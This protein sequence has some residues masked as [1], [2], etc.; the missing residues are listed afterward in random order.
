MFR[1]QRMKMNDIPRNT[2]RWAFL[3]AVLALLSL[4]FAAPSQETHPTTPGLTSAEAS[5]DLSLEDT[6]KRASDALKAA[7][8]ILHK[9]LP[10]TIGASN[11]WVFALLN[12]ERSGAKTRVIA[13]V[14]SN[15]TK[16]GESYRMCMFLIE[17]MKSGR[18]PANS[19][20]TGSVIGVWEW[21]WVN[22]IGRGKSQVTLAPDGKVTCPDPGW[23]PGDWWIEDGKVLVYWPSPFPKTNLHYVMQFTL[24]PD[25]RTMSTTAGNYYYSSVSAAR[26][27]DVPGAVSPPS[28]GGNPPGAPLSRAE[29]EW[30]WKWQAFA[31]N[32]T[33]K[34]TLHRGGR[35]T[36][37]AKQEGSW[38]AQGDK[39]F[40]YWNGA[41]PKTDPAAVIEFLMAPDGK[42]MT[43]TIGNYYT[44]SV[45]ATR[46]GEVPRTDASGVPPP[47][48]GSGTG[49]VPPGVKPEDVWFQLGAP[50][51]PP[52]PLPLP[53]VGARNRKS[54]SLD[55]LGGLVLR[56]EPTAS[57]GE[58]QGG[59]LACELV[60]VTAEHVPDKNGPDLYDGQVQVNVK[61]TDEGR[62]YVADIYVGGHLDYPKDPSGGG[63][64]NE[65]VGGISYDGWVPAYD[66][67]RLGWD[68]DLYS[69]QKGKLRRYVFRMPRVLPA[70]IRVE[71][72]E[73]LPSGGTRFVGKMETQFDMPFQDYRI[74]G[75]GVLGK[76]ENSIQTF[77]ALLE[78][79]TTEVLLVIPSGPNPKDSS[80]DIRIR[81]RRGEGSYEIR[82]KV[83][84]T[85]TGKERWK[86]A[87][88]DVW[89]V[90]R[91]RDHR[92]NSYWPNLPN[93]GYTDTEPVWLG[94]FN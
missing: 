60:S 53:P 18:V 89:P 31:S 57:D 38:W 68:T 44:R 76:R 19:G 13:T 52:A 35:V 9:P 1:Y 74:L 78:D 82:K 84:I 11:E 87:K 14:A 10:Q 88:I 39:V 42:S 29:G 2:P 66:F 75:G 85:L 65:G 81:G 3:I 77:A 59:R 7:G 22:A 64:K 69:P 72:Y 94:G 56:G 67:T 36:D 79:G 83:D 48:G 30:E 70:A 71:L 61:L 8:L 15:P 17:F 55:L 43:S 5:I 62:G 27:G 32:G 4:V 80:S 16:R 24:S 40:V 54:E 45:V 33:S 51:L 49:A 6:M 46:I 21:S 41:A 23:T 58:P 92:N 25:G 20:L 91:D 86:E 26:V 73:Q 50:N 47:A 63:A 12:C 37:D 34:V 93:G 28:V 90:F